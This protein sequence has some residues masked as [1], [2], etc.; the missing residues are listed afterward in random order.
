VCGPLTDLYRHTLEFADWGLSDVL[1]NWDAG[2]ANNDPDVDAIYRL[3]Q[4]LGVNFNPEM[5]VTAIPDGLMCPFNS[6]NT[7]YL[8]EAFWGLLLPVTTSMRVCDIWRGY[9]VQ[10]LLWE[11]GGSLCFTPPTVVQHRN[12]HTL[13]KDFHDEAALYRDAGRLVNFLRDWKNVGRDM[14]ET[15]VSL[16]K[17]MAGE[18]FWEQ[19]DVALTIAWV[20]VGT[21][22]HMPGRV[23]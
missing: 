18:G 9:W 7:V 4:P 17:A 12:P 16:A 23:S 11:I 13:L 5:F 20:E 6:Q 19:G 8:Q 1:E 3:T 10:R 2:L 22:A 21:P 14:P 15:I